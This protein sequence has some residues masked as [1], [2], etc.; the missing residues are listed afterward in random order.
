MSDMSA[1]FLASHQWRRLARLEHSHQTEMFQLLPRDL[2][3]CIA[4]WLDSNDLCRLSS[5]SFNLHSI[6]ATESLWRA[7][8][9]SRWRDKRHVSI[10][11]CLPMPNLPPQCHGSEMKNLS[12]NFGNP[13]TR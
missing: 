6:A 9:Q 8:C 3:V 12:S 11:P 1:S 10:D 13:F 7:L 2:I 4:S 5:V